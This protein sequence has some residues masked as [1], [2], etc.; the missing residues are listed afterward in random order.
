MASIDSPAPPMSGLQVVGLTAVAVLTVL[1]LLSM[2]GGF[3]LLPLLIPFHVWAARRSRSIGRVL[4]SIPA[5]LVAGEVA[6]AVTY[7]AVGEA[8]PW[9]WLVPVALMFSAALG[10][11]RLVRTSPPPAF[12]SSDGDSH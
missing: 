10:V 7:L 3:V 5:V 11:P 9:T 1:L 8:R 12:R 6:W 4:W 2:G